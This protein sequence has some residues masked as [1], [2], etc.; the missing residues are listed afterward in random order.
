MFK[1]VG[2]ALITPFTEDG[3]DTAGLKKLIESQIE[4]G[5]DALIILGT[6]GE[7]ATMTITERQEVIKF[8]VKEVAKR[9]PVIVGTGCNNTAVAIENSIQAE[10][11]GADG[12]LVVTPY[13]NKATQQ[14]L[15]EHY[16]AIANSV[17]IPI[18]VYN[19]PSRTGINLLP[20]T[21]GKIAEHKN[22]I[23]IK[24]ASGDI[25]QITEMAMAA[26]GKAKIYSGNDADILPVLAVGGEGVISVASNVIP[27]FIKEL[28]NDFFAGNMTKAQ[29]KQYAINPLVK[30]LFSEVN[31]IPVKKAASILGFCEPR[32]RL[33]LTI[34]TEEKA[35]ILEIEL[36]KFQ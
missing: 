17:N 2:T 28:T 25:V 3:I 14:G 1:G 15:V 9:I 16:F 18:I 5:I 33:P 13:Y 11:L 26:K 4:G 19:V 12:L 32:M 23:A 35:N 20:D 21:F 7:P 8:A 27:T 24:E 10:K 30:A 36:K 34:M 6:T 31:P 22:I 29:E